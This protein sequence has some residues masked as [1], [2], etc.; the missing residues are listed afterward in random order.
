LAS[1]GCQQAFTLGTCLT[2]SPTGPVLSPDGSCGG[3]KGYTCSQG[4][5]CSKSG[6]CGTG[7]SFCLASLG[8]QQPFTL[9]RCLSGNPTGPVMSPDGTCGGSKG[10]T[11]SQG[12]CCSISGYCGTTNDYCGNGCQ[13]QFGRCN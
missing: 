4:T 10:Y 6:Y 7:E 2:R 12:T 8:C 11:C 9:G 5:C 1:L 13:R 3:T